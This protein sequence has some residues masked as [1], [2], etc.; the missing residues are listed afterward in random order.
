MPLIFQSRTS[1]DTLFFN[2]KASLT[3]IL[4]GDE[5]FEKFSLRLTGNKNQQISIQGHVKKFSATRTA[6][7]SPSNE[8]ETEN[9]TNFGGSVYGFKQVARHVSAKKK[10]KNKEKTF[11]D[12][13]SLFMVQGMSEGTK[14]TYINCVIVCICYAVYCA[15]CV[16]V[17]LC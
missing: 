2:L 10:K 7:Q 14:S 12:I 11:K 13:H 17:C 15:V 4:F 3:Y 6:L 5:Q 9:K 1:E 8:K 16:Y